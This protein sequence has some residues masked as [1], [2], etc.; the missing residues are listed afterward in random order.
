MNPFAQG[1]RVK[2][3]LTKDAKS[4]EGDAVAFSQFGVGMGLAFA[5]VAPD[6]HVVLDRWLA[7]LRGEVAPAV[8]SLDETKDAHAACSL[9]TESDY[10]LEELLVVLM[11][12]GV[13]SE[14]EGEPLLR[15][16]LR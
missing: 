16:L 5:S 10:A 15:R 11:R 6:Q 14:Q 12:K 2:F 13:L 8:H 7:E 1:T 4:M 3:R 9:K